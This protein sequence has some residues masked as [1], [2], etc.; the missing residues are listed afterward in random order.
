MRHDGGGN[1]TQLIGI[2][3]DITE[4]KRAEDSLRHFNDELMRAN[5]ELEEFAYV[6]GHAKPVNTPMLSAVAWNAWSS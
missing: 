5:R 2:I 1:P 4:P 6:A 3:E